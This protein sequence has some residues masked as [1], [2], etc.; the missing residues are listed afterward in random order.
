MKVALLPPA[1]REPV[2]V[3]WEGGPGGY[4]LLAAGRC[5]VRG[6]EAGSEATVGK[7]EGEADSPSKQVGPPAACVGSPSATGVFR[8]TF[9][10][11]PKHPKS[12]DEPFF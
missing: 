11:V 9:I 2:P 4:L 6:G 7:G 3:I 5:S 10:A 8:A 1:P 12:G